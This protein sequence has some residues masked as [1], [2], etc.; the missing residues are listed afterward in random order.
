MLYIALSGTKYSKHND[1][2][3][4]NNNK[5]W[6][7]HLVM[8]HMGLLGVEYMQAWI[9]S[10]ENDSHQYEAWCNHLQNV[11]GL[12]VPNRHFNRGYSA[13]THIIPAGKA[14]FIECVCDPCGATRSVKEIRK[15]NNDLAT[16][17]LVISGLE[18][19][20]VNGKN[21]RLSA[22][23]I[24][25]WNDSQSLKFEVAERLHKVCLRFSYKRMK[26]WLSYDCRDDLSYFPRQS[27]TA[28]M[29]RSML[30]TSLKL[31]KNGQLINLDALV[32]SVLGAIACV[33]ESQLTHN[34]SNIRQFHLNKVKKFIKNNLHIPNLTPSVIA[35]S[36][37]LSVRY[38][39]YLF[40]EENNSLAEYVIMMR[41]ARCKQDLGNP[42]MVSRSLTEVAFS[43]GFQS[44]A[45]FS[46]RFKSEFGVS[47]ITY[48]NQNC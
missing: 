18:Y 16:I 10:S 17:Q 41:L 13:S 4:N 39:Y 23:D 24:L 12:W 22:G 40:S 2:D 35:Q 37:N 46:R 9:S 21:F 34:C 36:N 31:A 47:P 25:L 5:R 3:V 44:S 26:N 20:E 38:L 48:R 27:P 29:L 30:L 6:P 1:I 7:G 14:H 11:F 32:E 28:I 8:S 33:S 45:H 15:D 42:L 43:W 19:F